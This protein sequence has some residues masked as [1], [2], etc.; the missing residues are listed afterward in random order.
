MNSGIPG[1]PK[2]LI[3]WNSG[4]FESQ[5]YFYGAIVFGARTA[6]IRIHGVATHR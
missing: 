2:E 1:I 6:A 5:S 3:P 4:I